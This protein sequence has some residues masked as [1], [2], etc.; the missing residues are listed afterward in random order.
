MNKYFVNIT[1]DLDLKRDSESRFDTPTSLDGILESFCC[2]QN[3]L[4]LR[5]AFNTPHKFSFHEITENKGRRQIMRLDATKAFPVGDTLAGMLQSSMDVHTSILIKIINL[6]LRN[7]CF[8]DDLKTAEGSPFF[9]KKDMLD[10]E[11]YRPVSVLSHM[12]NV[13][14]RI[15]YIQVESFMKGNLSKLLAGFR[16]KS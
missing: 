3:I 8:L 9:K 12:L 13:F 5:E 10:K 14:E 15:M 4:K 1:A 7:A 11:S 2:Y 6:C 16:K